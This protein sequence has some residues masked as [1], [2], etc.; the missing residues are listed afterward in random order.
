MGQSGWVDEQPS[1]KQGESGWNRG[2]S[3]GKLGT[4]EKGIAFECKQRKYPIKSG[5]QLS[6]SE[7]VFS[8]AY[9]FQ[10]LT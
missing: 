6:I 10:F 2:L 9:T 7:G 1:W 3:W 4:L 5:I 8:Y